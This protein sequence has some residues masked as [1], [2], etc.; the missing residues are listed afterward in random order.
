METLGFIARDNGRFRL[1]V[2]FNLYGTLFYGNDKK[3]TVLRSLLFFYTEQKVTLGE[4][5]EFFTDKALTT[6][7]NDGYIKIEQYD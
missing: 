7:Q 6:F 2:D 3:V 1:P 5:R 4:L